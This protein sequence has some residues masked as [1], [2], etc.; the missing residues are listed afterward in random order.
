MQ[1]MLHGKLKNLHDRKDF[2]EEHWAV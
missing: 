1:N 2:S